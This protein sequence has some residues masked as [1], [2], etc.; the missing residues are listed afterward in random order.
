M[1][2]AI[3]RELGQRIEGLRMERRWSQERLGR[4]VGTSRYQVSRWE[5]GTHMPQLGHLIAL[6]EALEISID[7]LVTGRRPR[8]P[9]PKVFSLEER[10]MAAEHLN[11][12]AALM[13]L[14]TPD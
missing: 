1:E 10:R 5:N 4:K 11:S 13:K 8:L 14:Q 6:S 3:R 7:E 12:L 9:H 2:K